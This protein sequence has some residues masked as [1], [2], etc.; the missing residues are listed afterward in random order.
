M[1]NDVP[2]GFSL[3]RKGRP[4]GSPD[5]E[6]VAGLG[7][8]CTWQLEGLLGQRT[9]TVPALDHETGTDGSG[10]TNGFRWASGDPCLGLSCQ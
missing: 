3:K 1:G 9:Q 2:E 4:D 10:H 7:F 5:P 6:R 8:S